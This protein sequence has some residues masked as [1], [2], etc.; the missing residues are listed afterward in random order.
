MDEILFL[1]SSDTLV[2]NFFRNV[3]RTLAYV[4]ASLHVVQQIWRDWFVEISFMKFHGRNPNFALVINWSH[5]SV[6]WQMLLWQVLLET[7]E[8]GGNVM[9]NLCQRTFPEIQKSTAFLGITSHIKLAFTI[10]STAIL[11]M[12]II[13]PKTYNETM[14]IF[15]HN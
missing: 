4:F 11:K 12:R 13:A 2:Y 1:V 5:V 6:N 3:T 7:K 8:S 14:C 15:W 9:F 10:I